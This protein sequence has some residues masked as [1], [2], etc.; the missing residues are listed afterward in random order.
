MFRYIAPLAVF[1]VGFIAR[2]KLPA[3][4]KAE[5]CGACLY[6]INNVVYSITL[7]IAVTLVPVASVQCVLQTVNII[8]GIILFCIILDEKVTRFLILSALMCIGGV[9]LV[10][11]PTFIFGNNA[12][13]VSSNET[14]DVAN[15]TGTDHTYSFLSN[16][17]HSHVLLE[18]L[19]YIL[20]AATGLTLTLDVILLRKRPCLN[21]HMFE[22]L[23][24]CFLP[25]PIMSAILM[26][27]LETPAWPNNW[28]DGFCV[29]L[30][31]CSFVFL[32]PLYMLALKYISSNTIAIVSSSTVVFMLV[33]QYTV[34][35]SI[36]PG[37]R[38]WIEIVGVVLVML[39]SAFTSILEIYLNKS[40]NS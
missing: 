1:S 5:I 11:Q 17:I 24:W 2:R 7:Y 27:L 15:H 19:E 25:N 38:N 3:I 33:S 13:F 23:S 29:T 12:S 14:R 39:R 22:V 32:L 26:A 28:L 10:L 30:H 6:I 34:L 18:I 8:S 35:S 37:H 36:L 20:P 40:N 9:L 16:L 4:P 21:D 31:S